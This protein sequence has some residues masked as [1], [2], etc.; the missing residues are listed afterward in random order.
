LARFFRI[1][2]TFFSSKNTIK[3]SELREIKAKNLSKP[4]DF[5]LRARIYLTFR[6]R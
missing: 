3:K 6:A 1:V 5:Y 4:S 2:D